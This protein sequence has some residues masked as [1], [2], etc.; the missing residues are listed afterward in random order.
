MLRSKACR[1]P[2]I[3][4]EGRDCIVCVKPCGVNSQDG[5][6][7]MP[8]LLREAIGGTSDAILSVHRLDR[9][10]G[11]VMVY[12]RNSAAAAELSRQIADRRLDKRYLAVTCAAPGA[13]PAH[14]GTLNDLLYHDRVK[15]K[16]YVV[17]RRRNGVR[18]AELEYR[19]IATSADQAGAPLSLY[20]IHL[21]TG[22][23]HQIRAQLS[24]RKAPL[25]GDVRYGG[26]RAQAIGLWA[27]RLSF[28]DIKTGARRVFV[29]LPQEA[30]PAFYTFSEQIKRYKEVQ[31]I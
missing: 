15:N 23:T 5:P 20:D 19:C 29:C 12:A 1:V 31:N 7:G 25:L 22:R 21:L 28:C 17:Y 18:E 26:Q 16:T 13:L 4:Y 2:Q 27:Y 6:D 14:E 3:I 8:Q 9:E 11:G 10:V 24:S 30:H